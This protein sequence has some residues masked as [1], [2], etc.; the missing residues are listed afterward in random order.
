LQD[1]EHLDMDAIAIA[2]LATEMATTRTQQVA[3]IAVLKKAMELQGQGA[4]QLLMASA[5]TY[6]NPSHLGQSIDVRA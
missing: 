5:Q 3:Q 4:I 6:N 1:K 2:S